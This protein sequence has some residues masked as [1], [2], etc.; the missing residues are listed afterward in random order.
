M[1]YIAILDCIYLNAVLKNRERALGYISRTE[2]E[3]GK[4]NKTFKDLKNRMLK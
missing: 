3:L 2:E 4:Y 1:S